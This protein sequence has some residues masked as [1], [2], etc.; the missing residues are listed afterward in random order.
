M[1]KLTIAIVFLLLI[2]TG[3]K[4]ED[5]TPK[6][7]MKNYFACK[8]DGNPKYY[9][10][11]TKKGR[12]SYDEKNFFGAKGPSIKLSAEGRDSFIEF[13]QI[14]NLKLK[15][16]TR[17]L[18]SIQVKVKNLR[19]IVPWYKNG[20]YSC[21]YAMVFSGTSK[22]SSIRGSG[23]TDGWITLLLPFDTGEKKQF[24]YPRIFF[25]FFF[26]SGEIWLQCPSLIEL[27]QGTEIK[28]GYILKDNKIY[29]SKNM[30]LNNA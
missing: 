1:K 17:Y 16:N 10:I 5:N 29:P 21:F 11:K 27:P 25:F 20:A 23:S 28:Q 2:Q 6:N 13:D 19:T 22:W 8:D 7:L 24:K 14:R 3:V 9:K 18:F 15:A 12:V 26:C 30:E 4:S